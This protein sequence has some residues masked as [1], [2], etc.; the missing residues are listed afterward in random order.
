MLCI[1]I[2]PRYIIIVQKSEQLVSILLESL[3]AFL[4]P[5]TLIILFGEIAVKAIHLDPMLCK[6]VLFQS[7]MINRLN[8]GLQ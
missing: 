7:P 2:V 6:E 3:L 8:N 4:C 5:F 1:V